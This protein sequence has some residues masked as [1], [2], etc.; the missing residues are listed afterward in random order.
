MSTYVSEWEDLPIPAFA[1]ALPSFLDNAHH[2]QI[3]DQL[4]EGNDAAAR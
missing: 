1:K 3:H 2:V 4:E